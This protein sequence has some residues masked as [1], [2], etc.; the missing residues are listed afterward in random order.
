MTAA[1]VNRSAYKCYF[2]CT[3][4]EALNWSCSGADCHIKLHMTCAGVSASYLQRNNNELPNGLLFFCKLCRTKMFDCRGEQILDQ[5][6]ENAEVLRQLSKN[7]GA[8]KESL[9]KHTVHVDDLQ[10]SLKY[11]DDPHMVIDKKIEHILQEFMKD[12]R[13]QFTRA[14]EATLFDMKRKMD[15]YVENSD[16]QRLQL[17]VTDAIANF[18]ADAAIDKIINS[19][20]FER[21]D[22]VVQSLAEET[23]VDPLELQSAS[24]YLQ[25]PTSAHTYTALSSLLSDQQN[26]PKTSPL[27]RQSKPPGPPVSQVAPDAPEPDTGAADVHYDYVEFPMFTGSPGKK[28]GKSKK[29]KNSPKTIIQ[30]QEHV[31]CVCNQQQ[32]QQKKQKNQMKKRPCVDS[33]VAAPTKEKSMLHYRQK[34]KKQQPSH[35]NGKKQLQPQRSPRGPWKQK[36]P[37]VQQPPMSFQQQRQNQSQSSQQQPSQQ[38]HQLQSED[39]RTVGDCHYGSAMPYSY[40]AAANYGF[41]PPVT[42]Y[43]YHQ[44]HPWMIHVP[45]PPPQAQGFSA[46]PPR[47]F[48]MH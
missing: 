33:P 41:P 42:P 36:Q 20:L 39:N 43:A 34:Q 24:A 2:K 29:K 22:Y 5:Q 7:V 27:L 15:D 32:Q 26:S 18:K 23:S 37:F 45:Q 9:D 47:G 6:K 31:Q 12:C 25:Q 40:A 44:Y 16:V 35:E 38:P 10:D 3:Y 30:S 21:N 14:A 17:V 28:K 8:L 11:V 19:P 1:R 13:S 46:P 48:R 4:E